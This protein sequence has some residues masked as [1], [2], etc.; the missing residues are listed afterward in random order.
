MFFVTSSKL[1]FKIK[2]L[3]FYCACN[4][5]YF[6][7]KYTCRH[8]FSF[9]HTEEG[10]LIYIARSDFT[11]LQIIIKAFDN[12]NNKKA[13]NKKCKI[14]V[15]NSSSY[16]AKQVTKKKERKVT[17]RVIN[18]GPLVSGCINLKRDVWIK[19]GGKS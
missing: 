17:R 12:S 11:V 6:H 8:N 5:V 16:A 13:F 14:I 4:F 2:I 10:I 7:R 19:F 1:I 18:I 9:F 15:S 3:K